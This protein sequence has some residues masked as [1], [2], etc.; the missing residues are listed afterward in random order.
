MANDLVKQALLK[1]F[2]TSVDVLINRLSN[3]GQPSRF[4]QGLVYIKVFQREFQERNGL[5]EFEYDNRNGTY[6]LSLKYGGLSETLVHLDLI[7]NNDELRWDFNIM[8]P[9]RFNKIFKDMPMDSPVR[10]RYYVSQATKQKK[11]VI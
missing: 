9:L 10:L 2:F 1:D 4:S 5:V 8:Y 11:I 7:H 6:T 3:E